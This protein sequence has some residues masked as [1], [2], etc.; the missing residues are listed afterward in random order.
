MRSSEEGI[1]WEIP[2]FWQKGQRMLQP[3]K[4]AEKT[5]L[6]GRKW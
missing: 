1:S 3:T 2:Q 4:P 6:P 5:S